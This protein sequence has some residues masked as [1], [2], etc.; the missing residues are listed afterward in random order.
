MK[1]AKFNIIVVLTAL[2]LIPSFI[3]FG[4]TPSRTGNL[5]QGKTVLRQA[6]T[7]VNEGTEISLR[8]SLLKFEEAAELFRKAGNKRFEAN[9]LQRVGEVSN[10]LG[11]N[12]KALE[13]LQQALNIRQSVGSK[14]GTAQTLSSIGLIYFELGDSAKALDLYN[15]ALV[16][17][18]SLNSKGNQAATLNAI[19]LL[20]V[21]SGESKKALENLNLALPLRKAAGDRTGE[22]ITLRN[23]GLVYSNLGENEKALDFFNR[24]LGGFRDIKNIIGEAVALSNIGKLYLN[25]GDAAKAIEFFTQALPIHQLAGDIEK[26]ALTLSWMQE[27]YILLNKPENAVFYG[28]QAV[29]RYQQLRRA[30]KGLD[31]ETQKIYLKTVEPTYRKLADILISNGRLPEAQAVLDLLKDEEYE[32]LSRSDKKAGVVPYSQAEDNALTAVESLVKLERER[33]ELQKVTAP[34]KEQEDKLALLR[35]KIA[36][37]NKAF[38]NAL[39]ALG[40][41]EESVSGRVEEIQKGQELQS[42]LQLLSKETSSGVVALYTVIGT[43]TEKDAGKAKTKFGWVIM[44]REKTYTAYPIDV[45]GLEETVFQFHNALKSDEY[46]PKIPAQKIYDAIFRQTSEKQKRSLEQDLREYLAPYK[47]KTIMWSLDGVLRYIPMA[48]LYDGEQYLVENYRNVVFTS[49][50]FLWLTKESQ[51]SW[52]ALGF[53]VSEKMPNEEFNALPGVKTELE[54]II[55]ETDKTG[56]I[57]NGT[58]R[59]NGDFKK[60]TFFNALENGQYQI[61]HIASHYS[62]NSTKTDDSFLLVGDGHL[63]FGEMRE[64]KNLFGALDLLTL[65]ACDTAVSSNGKENESFAYLAQSLGA[66]SVIA[67]LWEVSDAGT[68]ELMIRFYKL[69]AANPELPKGETFRRAQIEMLAVDAK[70]RPENADASRS[71]VAGKNKQVVKLPLFKKDANKPFAHPH[72]W[73]AFVLIGNWR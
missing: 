71:G 21:S 1:A 69:R 40:K 49:Q 10:L 2:L 61:V 35:T 3:C 48:A 24:A 7:L 26:E 9:A 53:G 38:D 54:T 51:K 15:Q 29:N 41:S 52:N 25:T 11:E 56:G 73:A 45:E 55:R 37:A 33:A 30:I 17:W 4:Q 50:S 8:S 19:G 36:A 23:I 72:Y 20:Y 68:P 34:T 22:A 46:D 66:K 43:E 67:S 60:Q 12:Q 27:A 47:D 65:S 70:D 31:K 64:E 59:L 28:K 18:K 6:E 16:I 57:L 32:Q 44:V 13:S 14:Y 39:D 5:A 62:F 58:I 42:A 63:T